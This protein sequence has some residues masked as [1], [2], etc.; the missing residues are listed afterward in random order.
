MFNELAYRQRRVL[1]GSRLLGV[2]GQLQVEGRGEHAV[3]HL[4]AKR[5]FDHSEWLGSLAT[6]RIRV[7]GRRASR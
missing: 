7:P 4:V 3:V 2:A 5:L 1:L 6:A